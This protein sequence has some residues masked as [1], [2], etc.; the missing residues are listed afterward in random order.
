MET[1]EYE[2]F[3][4]NAPKVENSN[5]NYAHANCWALLTDDED[6]EA[7]GVVDSG[8]TSSCVRPQ[9]GCILTGEKSNKMFRVA[10][11][12]PVQA[13]EKAILPMSQ[14]NQQAREAE[15]VQNSETTP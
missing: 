13:T 4:K 3:S 11:G 9:D 10:T 14:S 8:A 2:K 7:T 1:R 15:V 5:F 12:Q 6:G